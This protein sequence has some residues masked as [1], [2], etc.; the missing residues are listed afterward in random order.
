LFEVDEFVDFFLGFEAG[1]FFLFL[2]FAEE[3][4]PAAATF[5]ALSFLVGVLSFVFGEGPG[6]VPLRFVF[7]GA[8]LVRRRLSS[9][10]SFFVRRSTS[11]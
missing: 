6:R 2:L 7:F 3:S 8:R 10:S 1:C 11:A 9:A 4:L 5:R